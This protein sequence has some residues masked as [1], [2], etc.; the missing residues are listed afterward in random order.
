MVIISTTNLPLT[1]AYRKTAHEYIG[2]LPITT[3]FYAMD[4]YTV[5]LPDE[6]NI[7]YTFNVKHLKLYILNNDQRFTNWK[8]I[9]H[10]PLPEFE[11]EDRYEVECFFREK[12]NP[13]TGKVLYYVKWKG[14]RHQSNIWELIENIEPEVIEEF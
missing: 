13:R 7:H 12:G 6:L 9:K 14:W 2:P 3:A 10:G 4:H 5:T 1:T 11:D 8:N